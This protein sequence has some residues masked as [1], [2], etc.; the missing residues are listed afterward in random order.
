MKFRADWV[1]PA[2]AG[3]VC[4]CVIGA[5]I[6]VVAVSDGPWLAYVYLCAMLFAPFLYMAWEE[7]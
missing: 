6:A 7:F 5:T 1:V 2:I 4:L 3:V